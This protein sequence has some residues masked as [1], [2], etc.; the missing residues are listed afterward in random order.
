MDVQAYIASGIL[1]EYALGLL[2][3][4]Q[5]RE[6]ETNA[7]RHQEIKTELEAIQKALAGY[8]EAQAVNPPAEVKSEL[9]TTLKGDE[10]R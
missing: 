10:E 8:A 9:L 6:V 7:S 4:E 2:T 1:E 5:S 3:E